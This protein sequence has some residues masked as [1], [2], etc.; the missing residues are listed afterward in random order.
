MEIKRL[1]KERDRDF[2]ATAIGIF[3]PR[4]FRPDNICR[5]RSKE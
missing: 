2:I 4:P 5:V 1:D 3:F